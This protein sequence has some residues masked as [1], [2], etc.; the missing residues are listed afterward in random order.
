[1][2]VDGTQVEAFAEKENVLRQVERY[3]GRAKRIVLE[4]VE[5]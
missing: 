1:M 2:T 3:L 4:Q 5:E